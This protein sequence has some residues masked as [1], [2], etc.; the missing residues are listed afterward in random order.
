MAT[1]RA[2]RDLIT[3]RSG[4]P[5]FYVRLQYNKRHRVAVQAVLGDMIDPA[6]GEKIVEDIFAK[7]RNRGVA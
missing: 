5:Y 7:Y 4:S 1:K 2:P 3:R 6:T